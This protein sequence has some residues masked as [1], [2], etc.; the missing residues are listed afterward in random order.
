MAKWTREALGYAL[1]V[2]LGICAG[3]LEIELGDILGTAL[4]VLVSTLILGAIWPRRPWRW[5]LIVGVFVPLAR[6]AAYLAFGR[7][8]DTAHLLASCLGFLTGIAG[9][10]AGAMLRLGIDE[11]FRAGR[12][13]LPPRH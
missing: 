2:L 13:C 4:F 12:G 1:A 9:S 11:L 7:R 8:T 5:I 6:I 10:Y 3:I